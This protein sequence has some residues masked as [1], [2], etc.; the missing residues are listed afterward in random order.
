MAGTLTPGD[1]VQLLSEHL[2]ISLED[3]QK[4]SEER[5]ER[6]RMQRIAEQNRQ[7]EIEDEKR[8]ARERAS[9]LAAWE[10]GSIIV[11]LDGKIKTKPCDLC[12]KGTQSEYDLK[13]LFYTLSEIRN[14]L[15]ND[16]SL[17]SIGCFFQA[18]RARFTVQEI[19]CTCDAGKHVLEIF[20]NRKTE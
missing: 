2:N 19:P 10:M 4:L 18:Q 17:L 11:I 20:M 5:K 3:L 14:H 9:V 6:E 15:I 1:A 7:N 12:T 16:R 8:H 13:R